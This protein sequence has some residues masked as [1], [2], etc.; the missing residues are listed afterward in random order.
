MD[1]DRGAATRPED[2]AKG[3]LMTIE[4]AA[5]YLRFHPSTVYRL[6]R[7]GKLPAVKVGKQWRLDREALDKQLQMR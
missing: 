5:Q 3:Q 1:A 2:G 6:A 4:E 7:R